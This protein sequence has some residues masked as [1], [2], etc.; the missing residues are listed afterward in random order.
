MKRRYDFT[1]FRAWQ[2]FKVHTGIEKFLF[3]AF[4]LAFLEL[5]D[6]IITFWYISIPL[7]IIGVVKFLSV[8]EEVERQEQFRKA[9]LDAMSERVCKITRTPLSNYYTCSSETYM[10]LIKEIESILPQVK[11][12]ETYQALRWH[13]DELERRLNLYKELLEISKRG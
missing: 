4:L 7:L 9:K 13:I 6:F 8:A 5:F 1:R 10:E 3:F 12:D 2:A 11:N